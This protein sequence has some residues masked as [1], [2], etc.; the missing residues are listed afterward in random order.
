MKLVIAPGGAVRC[1]YTESIDLASL[2]RL[3][4]CRA[5]YVEPD[6]AGRWH[7]DLS[8]VA[9]PDLGPFSHRSEA[10]AAEEA[11]LEEHHLRTS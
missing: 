6:E 10:L 4:I 5:S 3:A 9:G 1:L 7:A 11:W 2:G 8:P